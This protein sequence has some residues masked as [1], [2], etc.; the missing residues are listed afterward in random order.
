MFSR[1][2]WGVLRD[3]VRGRLS[4]FYSKLVK[5]SYTEISKAIFELYF[6]EVVKVY[7]PSG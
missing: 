2:D 1:I 6:C 7:V 5:K 3:M 4:L